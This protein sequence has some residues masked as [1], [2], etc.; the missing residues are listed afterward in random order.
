MRERC[1]PEMAGGRR[2][3]RWARPPAGLRKKVDFLVTIWWRSV[4]V[5]VVPDGIMH[6]HAGQKAVHSETYVMKTRQKPLLR[7]LILLALGSAPHLASAYYDPGVQRWI[8][9]DPKPEIGHRRL[10]SAGWGGFEDGV[11]LYEFVADNP[12][13]KVDSRGLTVWVCTRPTIIF[14]GR[15]THAYFWDDRGGTP[16]NKRACGK[17]GSSSTNSG[18]TTETGP[19]RGEA[20]IPWKGKGP[21]GPAECY[22]INDSDGKEDALMDCCFKNAAKGGFVPYANDCHNFVDDC[23]KKNDLESPPHSRG[24]PA[25]NHA[26][27]IQCACEGY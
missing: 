11:N 25:S 7:F 19:G 14:G 12:V 22:P 2:H 24:D 5:V 21:H 27:D 13:G 20:T 23:L 10:T 4:F 6:H 3:F 15:G 16:D 17:H 26:K 1:E 9:R 8:N 18:Q